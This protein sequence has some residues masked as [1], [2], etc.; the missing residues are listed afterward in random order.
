M[1]LRRFF[2]P[3]IEPLYPTEGHQLE[4]LLLQETVST[5]PSS[6]LKG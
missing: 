1:T 6:P 2:A 3:S 4:K 5:T